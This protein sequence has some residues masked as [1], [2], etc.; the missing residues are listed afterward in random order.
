VADQRNFLVE[1]HFNRLEPPVQASRLANAAAFL[2]I[3]RAADARAR[4]AAGRARLTDYGL[5]YAP[6]DPFTATTPTECVSRHGACEPAALH[7]GPASLALALAETAGGRVSHR[8]RTRDGFTA[9]S[10]WEIA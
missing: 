7:W 2:T 9:G 5:T 1:H 6:G 3:E 10:T 4:G 8:A